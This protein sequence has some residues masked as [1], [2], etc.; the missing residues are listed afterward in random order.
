MEDAA[1][2]P[3]DFVRRYM[4]LG[5]RTV[6]DM[7]VVIVMPV[8]LFSCLGKHLD[9]QHGTWPWLTILGFVIA[10]V[11]SSVIIRLRAKTYA[12][13]YQAIIDDEKKAAKR[14][15]L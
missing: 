12:A 4:A 13:A 11:I 15:P 14:P 3:T 9:R 5:L 6:G 7:G 10:A 1:K 8:V 2:H